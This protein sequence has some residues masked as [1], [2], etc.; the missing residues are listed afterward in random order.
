M[1]DK[2]VL[3]LDNEEIIGAVKYTDGIPSAVPFMSYSLKET[4]VTYENHFR[5]ID[6]SELE[7][8]DQYKKRV[9]VFES[10]EE[11]YLMKLQALKL[12]REEMS[13]TINLQLENLNRKI[14]GEIHNDYIKAIEQ[15]PEYLL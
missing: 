11:A 2:V 4:L 13:R 12:V 10:E 15:N 1:V 9:W 6:L 5:K 14:P 7:Y 3:V 8:G